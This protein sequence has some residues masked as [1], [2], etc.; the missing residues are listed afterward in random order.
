MAK[1]TLT[2]ALFCIL[3]NLGLSQNYVGERFSLAVG[4]TANLNGGKLKIVATNA[5]VGNALAGSLAPAA[6][7]LVPGT[8]YSIGPTA[9]ASS[10]TLSI[11]Y[12]VGA[13]A[14]GVAET[15]LSLFQV[16]NH[17]WELVSG[18]AVDT[19]TK[20]VSAPVTMTGTFAILSGTT[21]PAE[22][23]IYFHGPSDTSVWS[24]VTSK[25]RVS[26]E[27]VSF[28]TALAGCYP[29]AAIISP[30]RN[31]IVTGRVNLTGG[32]DLY[33]TSV[34]GSNQ[35]R[36]AGP[37][38]KVNSAAFSNDGLTLY[39][40]VVAPGETVWKIKKINV[41]TGS[42]S[43]FKNGGSTA[44]PAFGGG[45][46]AF[47]DKNKITYVSSAGV[48]KVITLSQTYDVLALDVSPDGTKLAWEN[49]SGFLYVANSDGTGIT[50]ISPFAV[51]DP[52]MFQVAFSPD[53]SM[54]AY[55]EYELVKVI[56]LATGTTEVLGS[57]LMRSA[58]YF[59]R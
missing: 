5:L 23:R 14:G 9:L 42:V 41:A 31:A 28:I 38:D 6:P 30:M 24:F 58:I 55:P 21:T 20:Y 3:A 17:K 43:S 15:S 11:K 29:G 53:G 37:F 33:I 46:V 1:A 8:A 19:S 32:A 26:A 54:V 36:L 35:K 7:N 52:T 2:I 56:T 48:A 25:D 13:L 47:A 40:S 22:G 12:D 57:G 49:S 10:F 39:V 34:D 18:S 4:A 59:W 45:A 51:K 50:Q 27:P 44:G 16:V